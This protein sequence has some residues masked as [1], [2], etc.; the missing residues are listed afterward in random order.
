MSH[1]LPTNRIP[2]RHILL[3]ATRQAAR[4]GGGKRGAGFG[5]AAF[6]AVFVDFLITTPDS[7]SVGI[8]QWRGEGDVG[9]YLHQ[10][11]RILDGLLVSDFI[12]ELL[13]CVGH[14]CDISGSG[15]GFG[16]WKWFLDGLMRD[17]GNELEGE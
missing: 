17:W 3:H 14:A 11:S 16:I 10:H 5:D 8:S 4:L 12:H 6:V 15:R 2:R 9:A 1:I 7:V 13:F